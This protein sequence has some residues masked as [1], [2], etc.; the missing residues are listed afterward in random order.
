MVVAVVA[1]NCALFR[2]FYAW[3][4]RDDVT[5]RRLSLTS[6]F[7]AALVPI[8]NVALIGSLLF[9]TRHFRRVCGRNAANDPP[10]PAGGMFF[11]IHLLLLGVLTSLYMPGA[12]ESY[13]TWLLGM[14]DY[15]AAPVID[16]AGKTWNVV[17]E[18]YA[19][20]YRNQVEECVILGL[21]FSGPLLVLM[22]IGAWLARRCAVAL[23]RRRFRA[24]ACLVCIGFVAL[25][26]T[27]TLTPQPFEDEQDVR[28]EFHVVDRNSGQQI[29]RA[30]IRITKAFPLWDEE[31]S[32]PPAAFTDCAGRAQLTG[33][34]EARGQRNAYQS[35]G[36]FLPWGRWLE[37]HAPGYRTVH[38]PLPEV[39]AAQIDLQHPATETISLV[40]GQSPEDS[41][42]DIAGTYATPFTGFGG[43][44]FEILA[45][46]RFA[47]RASGC[48]FLDREYGAV[49]RHG[50]EIRFVPVPN[51]GT[52]THPAV[53]QT[54]R[55]IQ[56]GRRMYFVETDDYD[57]WRFC[58]DALT[59]N[60]STD[61]NRRYTGFLRESDR[62][63]VPE[64]LPRLPLQVWMTFLR[65][66]ISLGNDEGAVVRLL[67]LLLPRQVIQL[68]SGT[69]EPSIEL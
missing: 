24:M 52:E 29:D 19:D 67:E 5:A 51:P 12:I 59:W 62:D 7:V 50:Q 56:W 20:D 16:Y 55:A 17:L 47:W 23:P 48:T 1:L 11:S 66:E 25:D 37:V 30:F 65:R 34:F 38:I 9:A 6:E 42:R 68:A 4:G 41:C 10:P 31:R 18:S 3:F 54:L 14:I 60:G 53:L 13:L 39:V 58:R 43:L 61:P 15:A 36:S 46:G 28:L 27:V 26:L 35:F 8:L 33:R 32:M 44:S 22:A 21:C 69:S 49:E 40:P 64:G 45:D 63:K 2:F 57:L